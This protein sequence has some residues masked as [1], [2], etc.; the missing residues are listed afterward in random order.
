[1]Y[2]DS[3]DWSRVHA[4]NRR[5]SSKSMDRLYCIH[6][7]ANLQQ[8]VVSTVGMREYKRKTK[9]TDTNALENRT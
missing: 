2:I 4:S 5:G 7:R 6:V 8:T 3:P 1:M 9:D